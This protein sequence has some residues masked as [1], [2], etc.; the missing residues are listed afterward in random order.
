MKYLYVKSATAIKAF[1]PNIIHA[2]CLAHIFHRQAEDVKAS[3]PKVDKV[4]SNT[5][6]VFVKPPSRRELFRSHAP[7][8]PV[9]PQSI[10]TR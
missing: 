2:T 6:K 4:V 8:I 9:L 3:S 5:K 7:S 10:M 1:Y